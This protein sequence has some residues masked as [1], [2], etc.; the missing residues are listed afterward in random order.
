MTEENETTSSKLHSQSRYAC[1]LSDG[2]EVIFTFV[3]SMY[4]IRSTYRIATSA[5]T[6]L[7][8]NS[9]TSG[10]YPGAALRSTY[11]LPYM[12]TYNTKCMQTYGSEGQLYCSCTVL[13]NLCSFPFLMWAFVI[14]VVVDGCAVHYILP[15]SM[16]HHSSLSLPEAAA[17]P[18][19]LFSWPAKWTS[20]ESSQLVM[21]V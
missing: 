12:Y 15:A 17:P 3:P 6:S 16:G 14:A 9:H 4:Q 21:F 8:P 11:I 7:R 19:P 13:H 18:P 10:I 2:H 1:N 5:G 20:S